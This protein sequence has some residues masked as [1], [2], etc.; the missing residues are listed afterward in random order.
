MIKPGSTALKAAPPSVVPPAARLMI[1]AGAL[2]SVIFASFMAL[3]LWQN[4]GDVAREA[5]SHGEQ[6]VD[7]LARDVAGQI[8]PY[9]VLL[10]QVAADYADPQTDQTPAGWQRLLARMISATERSGVMLLTDASGQVVARSD[11]PAGPGERVRTQPYFALHAKGQ[12]DGPYLSERVACDGTEPCIAL[13]QAL[14]DPDGQFAGVA[15]VL[16]PLSLLREP[17]KAEAAETS[18]PML[19]ARIDGT[20]FVEECGTSGICIRPPPDLI[21]EIAGAVHAP[22]TLSYGDGKRTFYAAPVPQLPLVVA[23]GQSI[24]DIFLPW[25][26]RVLVGTAAVLTVGFAS[27]AIALVLRHDLM[28]RS[29]LQA[30]LLQLS[31]T[32]DLTG[33]ANRR[34]FF[35]VAIREWQ[36][37]QRLGSP[38]AVL[39]IDI[40]RFK[41]LNDRLGHAAGDAVLQAIAQLIRHSL[42]RPADLAARYGGEEFTAILPD[43]DMA[44]AFQTAERIRTQVERDVIRG[45]HP[46]TVSI[47]IAAA[48]ASPNET[49]ENVVA[50]ADRALYRAKESGRNR[51]MVERIGDAH[52]AVPEPHFSD[53]TL[54]P[55]RA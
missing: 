23:T 18:D 8:F 52:V 40:D 36:R 30:E 47:G 28:R 12:V 16:L 54:D 53:A 38:V 7:S 6:R 10:R 9:R 46:V 24:R 34:R 22:V 27:I 5:A 50:A 42:R 20:L 14:K 29:R 21:R 26:Y 31:L 44:G 19:V 17:L 45:D 3:T 1:P 35:D 11:R 48:I 37:A 32:D 4:Y 41:L 13:S 49:F 15:A 39:M 55:T 51:V 25:R 33:I 43:T 2:I